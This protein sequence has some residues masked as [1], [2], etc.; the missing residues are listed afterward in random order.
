MHITNHGLMKYAF[1]VAQTQQGKQKS[2]EVNAS[3]QQRT[4][5]SSASQPDAVELS[6]LGRDIQRIKTVLQEGSDV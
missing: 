1:L 3:E 6:T 5:E 2:N 4:S